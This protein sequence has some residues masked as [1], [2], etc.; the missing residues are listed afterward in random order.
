MYSIIVLLAYLLYDYVYVSS[1]KWNIFM[2]V[3]EVF[4]VLPTVF[5]VKLGE[6]LRKKLFCS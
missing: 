6:R 1:K 3:K 2:T 5:L 4:T